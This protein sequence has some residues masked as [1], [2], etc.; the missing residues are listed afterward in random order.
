MAGNHLAHPRPSG[1]DAQGLSVAD[2]ELGIIGNGSYSALIDHV[3][4]VVSCCLP[5]FDGDPVFCEL[6]NGDAAAKDDGG[7]MF[8]IAVDNLARSEREYLTNTAIRVSRLYDANGSAVEITDFA[9]RFGLFGRMFR[10]MMIVR[11][12]RPIAGTPRIRVKLRPRSAY[13]SSDPEITHGSNHV[14][15]VGANV[16]LRLTTDAPPAYILDET[17]FFLEEPAILLL[18]ADETV[19]NVPALAS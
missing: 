18:G 5:R 7:G 11:V 6:L 10:P 17:P 15:Y 3:G 12:V 16:T 8:E 19:A 9:P 2:L 1:A 13:G 14:R 4:R